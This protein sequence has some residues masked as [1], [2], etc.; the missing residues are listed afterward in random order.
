MTQNKWQMLKPGDYAMTTWDG[1]ARLTYRAKHA[2]SGW[3]LSRKVAG[4]R[5]T[6]ELAVRPTLQELIDIARIDAAQGL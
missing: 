2:E 5:E 3:V 1:D 6:L 4:A